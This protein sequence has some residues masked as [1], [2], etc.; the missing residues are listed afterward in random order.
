MTRLLLVATWPKPRADLTGQER[1][2]AQSVRMCHLGKG[3]GPQRSESSK[4]SCCCDS[5]S[6]LPWPAR[7]K[8]TLLQREWT[9]IILKALTLSTFISLY[10]CI[11]HRIKREQKKL[12][13][14][15]NKQQCQPDLPSEPA[16]WLVPRSRQSH[17]AS[18]QGLVLTFLGCTAQ[19]SLVTKDLL[20]LALFFP[21]P[22]SLVSA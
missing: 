21:A 14:T 20:Q 4:S 18:S 6:P 2:S 22:F 1:L 10:F 9:H 3:T 7:I 5:F 19:L 11:S 16:P 13:C 8:P 12:W 17:P 15:G